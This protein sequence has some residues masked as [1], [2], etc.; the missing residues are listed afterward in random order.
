MKL[1]TG[2]ILYIVTWYM[3]SIGNMPL[4]IVG[5]IVTPWYFAFLWLFAED[6]LQWRV[7]QFKAQKSINE[8][9]KKQRD[10]AQHEVDI[11]SDQL[12]KVVEP[13]MK[14]RKVSPRKK[15]VTKK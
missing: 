6:E 15:P 8:I 9:Y 3:F 2:L 13:E 5:T 7:L 1:I 11:L 12:R 4:F 14:K 10:V